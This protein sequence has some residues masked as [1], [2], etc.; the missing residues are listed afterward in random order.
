MCYSMPGISCISLEH[1]V[2][3]LSALAEA[4]EGPCTQKLHEHLAYFMLYSNT[5]T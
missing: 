4:L 5:C 2:A 1:Q 3:H